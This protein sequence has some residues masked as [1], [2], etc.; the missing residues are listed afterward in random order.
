MSSCK[1]NIPQFSLAWSWP[2]SKK[3]KKLCSFSCGQVVSSFK[4]FEYKCSRCFVHQICSFATKCQILHANMK[5]VATYGHFT[6]WTMKSDHGSWPFAIKLCKFIFFKKS[7]H[8]WSDFLKK[9]NLQSF[10]GPSLGVNQTWTKRNDPCTQKVNVLG[11][12]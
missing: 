5:Y 8:A 2:W 9:M 4:S 3:T 12:F 7:D 1:G 11:F 6:P 10:M